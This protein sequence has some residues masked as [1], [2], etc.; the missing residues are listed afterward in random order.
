MTRMIQ[1]S[2]VILKKI[3]AVDIVADLLHPGMMKCDFLYSLLRCV[4]IKLSVGVTEACCFSHSSAPFA[5]YLNLSAACFHTRRWLQ[6][7][8]LIQVANVFAAFL[9]TDGKFAYMLICNV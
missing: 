5:L 9:K 8:Q 1:Q 3:L 2:S 7:S 4:F 6:V